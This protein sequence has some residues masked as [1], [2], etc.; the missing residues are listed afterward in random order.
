MP[1]MDER[2]NIAWNDNDELRAEEKRMYGEASVLLDEETLEKA[3]SSL[4]WESSPGASCV[5]ARM[6]RNMYQGHAGVAETLLPF[7][8]MVVAGRLS[9]EVMQTWLTGRL[10]LLPKTGNAW[11][12]L[13]I[14]SKL[15]YA[16]STRQSCSKWSRMLRCFLATCSGR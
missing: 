15:C 1:D 13:G 8:N 14:G 9:S 7:A 12:P 3:L 2:G 10:C 11:R 6:L 5:S 4:S 16:S